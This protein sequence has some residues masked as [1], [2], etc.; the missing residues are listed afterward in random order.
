MTLLDR[1]ICSDIGE[2]SAFCKARGSGMLRRSAPTDVGGASRAP[3]PVRLRRIDER[4]VNKEGRF[5][6][7]WPEADAASAQ[8]VWPKGG[9]AGAPPPRGTIHSVWTALG[10]FAPE[11]IP[12]ARAERTTFASF[13]LIHSTLSQYIQL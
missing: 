6:N 12:S 4:R 3:R 2:G 8:D 13:F 10:L 1:C 5:P 7:K 9:L 11:L